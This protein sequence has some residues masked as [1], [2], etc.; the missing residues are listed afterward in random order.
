[1]TGTR[2][3]GYEQEGESHRSSVP[4][5]LDGDGEQDDLITQQP[6]GAENVAGGGEFPDR[7]TPP[8]PAAKGYDPDEEDAPAGADG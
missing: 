3:D 7:N 2:D 8:S 6:V 1:M 4:L 5:D